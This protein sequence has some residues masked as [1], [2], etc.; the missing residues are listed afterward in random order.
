MGVGEGGG[1]RPQTQ[2]LKTL[3]A[4]TT[5]HFYFS[6]QKVAPEVS[7]ALRRIYFFPCP[8][9]A[10]G[11]GVIFAGAVSAVYTTGVLGATRS[12]QFVAF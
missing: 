10:V 11:F 9:N 3:L 6:P 2:N 8:Q 12:N 7:E 4:T 1:I 5:K